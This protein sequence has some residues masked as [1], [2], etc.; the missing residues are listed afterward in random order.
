MNEID[1]ILCQTGLLKKSSANASLNVVLQLRVFVKRQTLQDS[2]LTSRTGMTKT[3]KLRWRAASNLT[4]KAQVESGFKPYSKTCCNDQVIIYN[5]RQNIVPS[6]HDQG[7]TDERVFVGNTVLKNMKT[8]WLLPCILVCLFIIIMNM[9]KLPVLLPLFSRICR[10]PVTTKFV[11]RTSCLRRREL[12]F[13]VPSRH[14]NH[15]RP[16]E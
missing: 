15:S 1:L 7:G 9:K 5:K 3:K 2:V 16:T 13:F 8:F 12:T 14:F 11:P 6:K 4:K 10:E